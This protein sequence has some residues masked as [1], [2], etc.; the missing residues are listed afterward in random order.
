[1][2][3]VVLGQLEKIDLRATVENVEAV[4]S[5]GQENVTYLIPATDENW[6]Q[7]REGDHQL[8]IPSTLLMEDQ[9]PSTGMKVYFDLENYPFYQAAKQLIKQTDK[10]KGVFRFRRMVKQGESGSLL[11]E[12]LYVI[13]SLLGHPEDVQVKRT[14]QSIKPAHTILMINFGGGTMAHVEYTV[15]DH[16]KVELEW[17]GNNQII[18]FN[19]DELKPVQPGNKTRLPLMYTVD[20][21]LENAHPVD[22]VLMDRLNNFRK[23]LSRGEE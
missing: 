18:E 11:A 23:L 15:S 4:N 3:K 5:V 6:E 9:Q 17:S 8:Y 19:S 21:I 22:Q 10:P 12:D 20:A 7:L 2:G 14:D 13:A 1:M 16:D